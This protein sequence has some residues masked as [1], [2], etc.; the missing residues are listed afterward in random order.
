MKA[1]HPPFV[2]LVVA[3]ALLSGCE[4]PGGADKSPTVATVAGEAI[5]EAELNL[6]VSRLNDLNEAQRAEARTQLLQLLVD[7]RLMVAAARQAGVD[8]DPAVAAAMAHASRQV[9]AEAY[10]ERN[11]QTVAKPTESE[12]AEYYAQHPELF[13]QRRIYRVQELELK[14]DSARAAEVEAKLQSSQSMGDFINWLKEQG[15]EGKA[16]TAVK[17]AEQIPAPLLARLAR[18]R[19]GQVTLLPSRPGHMLVQQLLESQ[20]QPVTLEQSAQAI[21]RAL[22]ARKRKAHMEAEVKKLREAAKIEYASG[23]APAAE[24]SGDA[25]PVDA[26]KGDDKP[27]DQPAQE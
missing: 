14:V 22:L 24:A 9:L 25:A 13:G 18:M 4:K 7:Q 16:A 10:A 15:I 1:H 23:F 2:A 20:L 5:S 12:V 6:A 11:T 26:G 21:E 3:A 19:D 27:A 8:K 17:P